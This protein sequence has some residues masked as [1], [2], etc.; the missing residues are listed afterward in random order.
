ML[1]HQW[2]L[3]TLC[4]AKEASHKGLHILW[5]HLYQMSKLGKSVEIESRLVVVLGLGMLGNGE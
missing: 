2:I 1:Q 5:F 3:K 4:W